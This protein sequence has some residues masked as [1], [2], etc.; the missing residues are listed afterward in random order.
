M[1]AERTPPARQPAAVVPLPGD[2]VALVR[3][4]TEARQ[5][6]SVRKVGYSPSE[7]HL[8]LWF[9]VDP[10]LRKHSREEVRADVNRL[11][12]LEED[13]LR[14]TRALSVDVHVVHLD[15]VNA[16][17]LPAFETHFER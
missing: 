6:P 1:V 10:A 5:I 3:F 12:E 4:L 15:K 2:Q 17:I 8:H 13:L 9:L 14:A 16:E 11:Y 7:T